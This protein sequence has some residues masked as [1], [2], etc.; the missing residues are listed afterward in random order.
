MSSDLWDPLVGVFFV[1]RMQSISVPRMLHFTL[2]TE[3]APTPFSDSEAAFF[4]DLVPLVGKVAETW[5]QP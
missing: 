1:M 4:V 2:I 3:S 5:E